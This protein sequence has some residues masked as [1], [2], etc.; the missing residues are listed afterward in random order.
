MNDIQATKTA[1]KRYLKITEATEIPVH[2]F[3]NLNP[4]AFKKF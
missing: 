3:F 4:P 2:F 1:T